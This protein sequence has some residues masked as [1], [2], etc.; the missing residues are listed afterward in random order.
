MTDAYFDRPCWVVDLLPEQVP[1]AS[2]GQFFAVERYFLSEG[3]AGLR[4]RFAALLLKLNCD[5]DFQVCA[6]DGTDF[7]PNPPPERLAALVTEGWTDLCVELP[8]E[9][10]LIT[11]GRDDLYLSVYGPSEP[12]RRRIGLLAG[13]EGL[14][15]RPAAEWKGGA[16]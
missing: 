3:R 13:A 9:D 7:G 2:P 16:Q 5:H 8:G 11:V 14:F 10:A 6:P 1:A 4:R 15:L 12:L